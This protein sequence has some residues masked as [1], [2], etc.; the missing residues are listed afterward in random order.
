MKL[1]LFRILSRV[2]MN[3]VIASIPC[4]KAVQGEIKGGG[5]GLICFLTQL[6]EFTPTRERGWRGMGV[7]LPP[8]GLA[9]SDGA[10]FM[11]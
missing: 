4:T 5:K 9:L 11:C 8:V 1:A 10:W 7:G 2:P 3:F 6:N